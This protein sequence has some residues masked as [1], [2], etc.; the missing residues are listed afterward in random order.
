MRTKLALCLTVLFLAACAPFG[1]P[2]PTDSG[3]E[4]QVL[5][6]PT[7][8]VVQVD[9]P[10]PDQ[11]YQAT[12]TVLTPAGGKIAQFQTDAQGR[13]RV[14]LAA[15]EY[16][17]RPESP[18]VMPHAPEQTFTVLAGQFTRIIVTYDSGIR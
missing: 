18:G 4:G 2:T 5:I 12:L 6:G 14:A 10:C 9:N 8:P 3:V 7:C 16:I 17:L 15:G 13:F 11:P 1:T